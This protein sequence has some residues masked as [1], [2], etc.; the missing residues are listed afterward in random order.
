MKEYVNKPVTTTKQVLS[1]TSCDGCSTEIKGPYF[2]VDTYH[3]DW[4][5]DSCD[6]LEEFDF[7][8]VQCLTPHMTKYLEKSC[9]TECYEI[10]R[11]YV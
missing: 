1:K 11:K 8:S 6:S 10:K 4:G 9:G 3:H 5:N 2:E 7:C